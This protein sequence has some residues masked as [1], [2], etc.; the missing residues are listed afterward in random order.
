[1]MISQV[2]NTCENVRHKS[3]RLAPN[4]SFITLVENTCENVRHKSKRLAPNGV[5]FYY[6]N[7]AAGS[8]LRMRPRAKEAPPSEMRL[9]VPNMAS[10]MEGENEN[11]K[12]E[13]LTPRLKPSSNNMPSTKPTIENNMA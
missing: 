3:K 12:P 11:N 5:G 1:M 8:I 6:L 13:L 10:S 7:T 2:E 4:G 9:M